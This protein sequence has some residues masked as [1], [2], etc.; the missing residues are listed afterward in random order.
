MQCTSPIEGFHKIGGG[1]SYSRAEGYGDRPLTVRCGRCIGCRLT[2][3]H[4]WGIRC[5][6]E[7]T[8]HEQNI[9]ATLTYAPEKLP[10][11]ETLV[12]SHMQD[13]I[14]RLRKRYPSNGIR[15]FYCGEYGG[16]TDRPHY[17]ALIF[18]WEPNDKTLHSSRNGNKYYNSEKLDKIWGHGLCNFSDVTFTSACYTAGY[19]T[20]KIGGD[21]AEEHYQWIDP[22]T[23]Q[24]IQ[25]LPEFSGQSLKPGIGQ[26]WIEKYLYDVYPRSQLIIE[27]TPHPPPRYYDQYCEK[28]D[29]ALWRATLKER[30]KNTNHI[31]PEG[32]YYGTGRQLW[33]RQT[34]NNQ[35]QLPRDETK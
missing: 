18:G 8:L 10:F 14:K 28:T 23:G 31:K 3:A 32:E 5:Y 19:I 6:H 1:F 35:R 4:H 25:R 20:K 29:P 12:R 27:G 21:Y 16:E 7:S 26:K 30:A 13:F 34:I 17:H 15:T 24:I 33:A 9:F 2:R 22:E 11:G